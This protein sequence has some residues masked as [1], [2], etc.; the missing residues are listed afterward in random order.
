[1]SS[2]HKMV[3]G[4]RST[5][6]AVGRK[7]WRFLLV[8]G[9]CTALQYMVLAMLVE[10]FAVPATLAST[11]GYVLSSAM[12]YWLNYSFTFQSAALHRHSLPKFFVITACGLILN[13]VVTFLGITIYGAHYLVAQG[14]ATCVTLLWNFFANL[15]WTF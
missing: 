13:G 5:L 10:G 8:G 11:I 2:D 7:L 12:N 1:M 4:A 15:R 14:A 9:I 3:A 6:S